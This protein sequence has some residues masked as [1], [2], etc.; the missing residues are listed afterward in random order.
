MI[1]V[2]ASELRV[3]NDIDYQINVLEMLQVKE[4]I[5]IGLTS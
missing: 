2:Q 3:E 1:F 4:M 5:F